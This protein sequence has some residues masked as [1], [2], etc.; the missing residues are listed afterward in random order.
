MAISTPTEYFAVNKTSQTTTTAITS[1]SD[2]PQ[3]TVIWVFA[4]N[5]NSAKTISTVTD[6][7]TALGGSGNAWT[8]DHTANDA[9]AN[10]LSVASCQATSAITSGQTITV[11]WAVTASASCQVWV[12]ACTGMSASNVFDTSAHSSAN[13]NS[14]QSGAT[15]TLATS[16]EIVWGICRMNTA[17]WTKNASFSNPT[18][19]QLGTGTGLEY[20]IVSATT[21]INAQGSLN[22]GSTW[23]TSAVAYKGAAAASLSGLPI[24]ITAPY[25]SY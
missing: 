17:T 8:V 21:G 3:G 9:S 1:T 2:I 7:T 16:N 23:V 19:P 12:Q 10:S 13:N 22:A 4:A 25:Q 6:N 5:A 14:P 24:F 18:T 11:T 15:P 20:Q